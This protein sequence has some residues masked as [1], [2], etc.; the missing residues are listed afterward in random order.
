MGTCTLPGEGYRAGC[1]EVHVQWRVGISLCGASHKP[2]PMHSISS[3]FLHLPIECSFH[4]PCVTDEG[5]Q[6][7]KA[8]PLPKVT[9]LVKSRWGSSWP[10]HPCPCPLNRL[11][12]GGK[13]NPYSKLVI[14]LTSPK[15]KIQDPSWA[16]WSWVSFFFPH[17]YEFQFP[18][19]KNQGFC[20]HL[21][22]SAHHASFMSL[23]LGEG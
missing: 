20:E 12:T 5:L 13:I 18:P 22:V 7:E 2:D 16:L 9:P 17:L 19:K 14:F 3:K 23:T 10:S 11:L 8:H 21:I 6:A 1:R 15:I 4:C